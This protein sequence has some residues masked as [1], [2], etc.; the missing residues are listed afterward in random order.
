MTLQHEHAIA[1][2]RRAS[3][4]LYIVQRLI[5]D[6][7]APAW[8][9]GFHAQQAVEKALKGALSFAGREYPRTHNLDML[10]QLIKATGQMPPP[11]AADLGVLTP[12]GVVLR[13]EDAPSEE[14]HG[15]ANTQLLHL[16]EEVIS[17]ARQLIDPTALA[18]GP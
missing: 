11:C 5:E 15:V 14:C 6:P 10:S 9:L 13:Y 18:T 12:F 3:D 16:A 7:N 4:D 17:W 8:V 1:L 2:L